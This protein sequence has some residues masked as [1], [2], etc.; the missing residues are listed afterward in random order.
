MPISRII[1]R[2]LF[3]KSSAF[4]TLQ[5]FSTAT[6]A[7]SSPAPV[8]PRKPNVLFDIVVRRRS[9]NCSIADSLNKWVDEGK[10]VKK[11]DFI[12]LTIFFRNTKNFR[13]ALQVFSIFLCFFKRRRIFTFRFVW[14]GF[15]NNPNLISRILLVSP[16]IIR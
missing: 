7:P 3:R 10:H 16:S 6:D 12:N 14:L 15:G 4:S 1:S 2:S 8:K 9:G 13:A 11:G 5:W